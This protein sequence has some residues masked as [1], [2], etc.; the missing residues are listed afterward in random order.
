M[1]ELLLVSGSPRRRELL[2]MIDVNYEV[3]NADI[4]EARLPDECPEAYVTRLASAKALAGKRATASA[5]PALGADTIVLLEGELLGKPEDRAAARSMLRR[6]SGKTHTVL[7]AVAVALDEER[8]EERLNQT[9]VTMGAIPDDWVQAYS[10]LDEPMD[11]AGAYAVQG[12]TGQWIK[13]IDG[14]YSGVMG[15]PLFE[16]AELLRWAGLSLRGPA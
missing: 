8:I 12:L 7:T 2:T 6:L 14:S 10:Q 13:H 5:L 16:T 1:K 11:K 3:Y 9:R 15:L 4:D